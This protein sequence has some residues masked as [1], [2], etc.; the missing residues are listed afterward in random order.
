VPAAASHQRAFLLAAAAVLYPLIFA[1][2]LLF[3]KPGLGVGH[4]YYV[5]VAM[6]ALAA[7]PA[8]GTAAGVAATGLPHGLA[9]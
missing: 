1:A 5:P 8:W 6:V 3:E 9:T 7:G 4:F 2:F